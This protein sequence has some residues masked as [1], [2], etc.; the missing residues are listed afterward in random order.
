VSLLVKEEYEDEL[1]RALIGSSIAYEEAGLPWA[2]RNY[3]LAAVSQQF[4]A[5]SRTGSITELNPATITRLYAAELQLG[6]VP[7]TLSAFHLGAMVSHARATTHERQEYLADKRLNQSGPLAALL[8]KTPHRKLS[9]ISRLPD[10]LDRL[11]LH[12]GRLALLFLMGREDVLRAEGWIPPEITPE[13]YFQYFDSMADFARDNI[14]ASE[15]DY[16]IGER[17]KLR[18]RVLGCEVI[19]SCANN[20]TSLSVGEAILGTLEA[21]LATSLDFRMLPHSDRLSLRID[22]ADGADL[23]PTLEFVE[24]GGATVGVVTHKRKFD[25]STREE[26]LTFPDWL[27]EA[28]IHLFARLA[29]P[30][31]FEDWSATVLEQENAFSR[32][33]LFSNIPNCMSLIHGDTTERLSNEDWYEDG[34]VAYEVKR[35]TP[36]KPRGDAATKPST[37]R[38]GEGE[39]PAELFDTERLKHSDVRFISPINSPK[40]Q[41]AKW[42]AA[43]FMTVPDAEDVPPVFCL[44]FRNEAPA[45]AIFQGL[46]DRFGDVDERNELRIAIIRGVWTSNPHAYAVVVGP[47]IDTIPIDGTTRFHFG[48]RIQVMTPS[49]PEN[50]DRFL[51]EYRRHGRYILAPAHMS[52][53]DRPPEPM[54]DIVLGKYD[55][56][57][58]NAWEIGPNDPDVIALDLDDPPTIPSGQADAPALK[59]ME[60]LRAMRDRRPGR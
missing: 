1:L 19:V 27:S 9:V 41:E 2:S 56:A 6:R 20:I 34:D 47:N 51:A 18:S 12:E 57:V 48:S 52:S 32:A 31:S 60:R 43:F 59:A 14:A 44:G 45:A 49:S 30:A 3:A 37:L 35:T 23:R 55:L 36:W 53:P 24:E 17:A 22:P 58:R 33:L 29:S 25:C 4:S 39:P 50:L 38:P 15:P 7:Y 16:L 8:L 21:L 10:A 5:F 13:G 11:G 28:A 40:W 42:R 26:L 46:N 54:M